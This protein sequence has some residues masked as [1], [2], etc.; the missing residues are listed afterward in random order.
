MQF[1]ALSACKEIAAAFESGDPASFLSN[2]PVHQDGSCN[3]LQH[4]AGR[5]TRHV[6][7]HAAFVTNKCAVDALALGLDELGGRAVNLMPAELPQD[8]YSRVLEG[9]IEQVRQSAAASIGSLSSVCALSLGA[10]GR[11]N[12]PR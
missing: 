2:L 11:H 7:T 9:V 4:Y 10:G 1:Q 6:F 3:G 5:A 12:L 8:V